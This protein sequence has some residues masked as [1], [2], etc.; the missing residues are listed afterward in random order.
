MEQPQMDFMKNME[1]ELNTQ[2]LTA[3]VKREH[4]IIHKVTNGETMYSISR[5]YHIPLTELMYSNP[6]VDVY[7]LIPGD[8][9]S[10]P[11]SL[12]QE[13]PSGYNFMHINQDQN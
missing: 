10:V 11:V 1:H 3:N 6:Y 7:N 12:K 2:T 9:L 8:E 13:A 4:G 5:K